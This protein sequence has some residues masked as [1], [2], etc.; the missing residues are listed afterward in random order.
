MRTYFDCIP[1]FIRQTIDSLRVVT[2]DEAIHEHVLR[3]VLALASE[4]DLRQTPPA[5]AQKIHRLIRQSTEIDDPYKEM[6][7]RFNAFALELYPGLQK[8]VIE[9]EDPFETAVRLAI[10][11]NIIDLG[12]KSSLKVSEVERSIKEALAVPFDRTN[13][14]EF[15][16]ASV[17]SQNI[18]YIGDN[19]GEIVFDRF[20][21]E[22]IG[23]ERITFAVRGKP[24]I[25]DATI[26][27]AHAVGLMDLVKVIDSG[28]DVP[29]TILEFCSEEFRIHFEQSDMVI[30]KGQGNFE[31]LSDI[32]KN[33]F[34][35][36][37]A[38]CSVIANHLNCKIGEM[39]LHR[40][41]SLDQIV[42]LVKEVE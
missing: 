39:I 31:S 18:L 13:L 22:Q 19:S 32:D 28:D 25:N 23:P 7:R 40:S 10:A 33:I 16:A 12:V 11:G 29:G 34:F 27:D 30:A 6:K 17:E 41:K 26:E 8:L 15:K 3:R 24:V 5:M 38:K 14:D 20:L 42:E 21:V 35:L 2:G 1:C 37:R 36:L 4:M 9:S